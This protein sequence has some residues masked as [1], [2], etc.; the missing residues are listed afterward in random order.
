MN[1]KWNSKIF[2]KM[3]SSERNVLCILH[4]CSLLSS[5]TLGIKFVDTVNY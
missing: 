2:F 4:G 5:A 1:F 3:P